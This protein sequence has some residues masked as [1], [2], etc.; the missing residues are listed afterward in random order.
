MC[1]SAR[2][3][4]PHRTTPARFRSLHFHETTPW[5]DL[6]PPWRHALEWP[7]TS[8]CELS[9]PAE[10]PEFHWAQVKE[11][12]KASCEF[13]GPLISGVYCNGFDGHICHPQLICCHDQASILC[14]LP[15]ANSRQPFE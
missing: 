6:V 1:L 4:P 11:F 3:I 14:V 8:G 2:P 10:R 15:D 13:A 5:P 9:S 7:H 12:F